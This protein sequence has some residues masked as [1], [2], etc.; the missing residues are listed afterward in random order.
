MVCVVLLAGNGGR[1]GGCGAAPQTTFPRDA[2]T[3]I[4][5]WTLPGDAELVVVGW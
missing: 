1:L 2:A 3:A 4:I 5:A